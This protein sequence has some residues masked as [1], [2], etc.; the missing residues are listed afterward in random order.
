MKHLLR[1]AVL[2]VVL[3]GCQSA[4]P[5]TPAATPRATVVAQEAVDERTDKLTIES[6][7]TG[8]RR[9]VWVMKPTRWTEG[10]TGWRALYMLHSCCAGGG[11]DWLRTGE[12]AKLTAGLD[13][14]V[15]V[16]EGGPMGWY[17]DWLDGPGWETFHMTEVRGLVEPRY[18]VGTRRAVVGY[19]MGGYGAFMYAARHPGV[20]EAAASLSGVLDIREDVNGYRSFF[21]SNGE[22]T[23]NV[24]GPPSEWSAHNPADQVAHLKGVRLYASTGDGSPGP[25]DEPSTTYDGVE[26]SILRQNTSFAEAAAKAGVPF[27]KDFYGPGTHTWPYWIRSLERALPLLL[28]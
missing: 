23:G 6:P 9:S 21:R 28:P 16:P 4:R 5:P 14:V 24:W 17:T 18:G 1:L 3:C 13:A 2:T 20:F 26:A 22:D 10:S 27:T 25:L 15:I 11:W 19:S 8:E 12:V 7:A